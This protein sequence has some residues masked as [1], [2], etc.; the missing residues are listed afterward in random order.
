M[1]RKIS[2][3]PQFL[4]GAQV[5]IVRLFGHLIQGNRGCV[6]NC[7]I[8][9]Q[10]ISKFLFQAKEQFLSPISHEM[11]AQASRQVPV[12]WLGVGV[13]CVLVEWW[14]EFLGAQEIWVAEISQVC[15]LP[16]GQFTGVA[17]LQGHRDF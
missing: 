3:P 12:L 17:V 6:W 8:H 1:Q 14:L 7:Q 11:G 16:R 15:R 10:R 4:I 2:D 5:Q 13:V 9:S